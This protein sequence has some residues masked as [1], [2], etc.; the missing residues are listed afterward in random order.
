MSQ[1]RR[2]GGR[3]RVGGAMWWDEPQV[4]LLR[5]RWWSDPLPQ[6]DDPRE[7]FFCSSFFDF[8]SLKPKEDLFSS[9]RQ[10]S[11]E[12]SHFF[13]FF[14]ADDIIHVVWLSARPN[15]HLSFDLSPHF[16][17]VYTAQKTF[18]GPRIYTNIFD[19]WLDS[20]SV[21]P[22]P[23]VV[24][25]VLFFFVCKI[26]VLY[27]RWLRR[28]LH[29]PT[30]K[31]NSNNLIAGTT[32]IVRLWSIITTLLS[33]RPCEPWKVKPVPN[34]CNNFF[35]FF[36]FSILRDIQCNLIV[37]SR[38]ACLLTAGGQEQHQFYR[39]ETHQQEAGAPSMMQQ[40]TCDKSSLSP[41]PTL[42]SHNSLSS[43]L[44]PL[45]NHTSDPSNVTK[46]ERSSRQ[47]GQSSPS[48]SKSF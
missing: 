10:H 47:R 15:A 21:R 35:F 25:C 22:S 2:G 37:L 34:R 20:L 32:G 39:S 9:V 44:S 48:P 29:V 3:T 43:G 4:Q 41:T 13:I 5:G 23:N 33:A 31:S 36:F 18:T 24:K 14:F 12:L 27:T 17:T 11:D 19:G 42:A 6:T 30:S 40:E 38:S 28:Q 1:W 8:P 46:E 16:V 7:I 45:G 26:Q